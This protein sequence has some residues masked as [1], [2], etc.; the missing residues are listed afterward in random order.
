[1]SS[2]FDQLVALLERRL[3]KIEQGPLRSVLD[4][5][6]HIDQRFDALS[7]DQDRL[8]RLVAGEELADD[9]RP[10]A[11]FGGPLPVS[12]EP[13]PESAWVDPDSGCPTDRIERT[14]A[15]PACGAAARSVVCRFNK[16]ITMARMPDTEAAIYDYAICHRCGLVYATRRPSGPRFEW[17][18]E[19]FEEN[20]G[21]SALGVQRGGKIT[22]SSYTLDDDAR[23]RLRSLASHGVF[24]SEHL[25]LTRKQYLWQLEADRF[26]N[27]RHV[28]LLGSFLTLQAPRVL[29][30]RSRL[31]SISEGL[32]RLYGAKVQAMAMFSNQRFLI[33][34][35]YGIQADAPLNFDTFSVP[36]EAPFD[37]VVANHMLTHSIRPGEYLATVHRLLANGGHLYIYNEPLEDEFLRGEKSMFNTLNA[38][39]LQAFDRESL[40]RVLQASG[41]EVVHVGRDGHN[42]FCL[43]RKAAGTVAWQPMPEADLLKRRRAYRKADDL[44]IV[45][46]PEQARPRFSDVWMKTLDRV[47]ARGLL[48]EDARGRLRVMRAVD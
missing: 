31:G 2:R 6:Q 40:V 21:R 5:Q 26:A 7:R 14:T 29:E 19:H 44:S 47:K 42:L 16:M 27:S 46:L 18:L 36:Y 4:R 22:L 12:I 35:V 43:A 48:A 23:G 37:L 39:H 24:V 8:R 25:G 30:I 34:E 9:D 10:R 17:L 11:P 33:E 13:E 3:D 28:D 45:L 38:F 1:M 20:L 32:R 15:C 41:F